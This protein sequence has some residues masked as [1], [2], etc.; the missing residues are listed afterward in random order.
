MPQLTGSIGGELHTIL[1]KEQGGEDAADQGEA[2]PV[3]HAQGIYSM[4]EQLIHRAEEGTE[5]GNEQ[6]PKGDP[7]TNV[8]RGLNR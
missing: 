5:D 1:Q 8:P 7:H 4:A 3:H 2:E 6:I